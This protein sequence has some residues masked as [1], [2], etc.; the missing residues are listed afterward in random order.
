KTVRYFKI[1]T[2]DYQ[3]HDLCKLLDGV[4]LIKKEKNYFLFYYKEKLVKYSIKNYDTEV[5]ESNVFKNIN[6]NF[7]YMKYIPTYILEFIYSHYTIEYNMNTMKILQVS[8]I[9]NPI[10]KDN[11]SSTKSD[12]F[13]ATVS[14]SSLI[15]LLIIII[16]V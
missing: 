1:C 13:I 3:I 6:T 4:I 5:E 8:Q 15:S 11:N 2:S 16:L 9:Y 10:K 12:V 7:K 14:V